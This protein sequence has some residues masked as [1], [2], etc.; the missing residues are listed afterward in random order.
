MYMYVYNISIDTSIKVDNNVDN[1][2]VYH[3][4]N[5]STDVDANVDN[6]SLTVS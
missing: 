4:T 6:G 1:V 5:A 3:S 2:C